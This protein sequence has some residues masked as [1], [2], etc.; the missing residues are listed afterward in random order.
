ML[1][2]YVL[3]TPAR[4]EAKFI[5]LTLESVVAQ[6]VRPL[7]WVIVSDGSTDGTDEIVRKF[8]DTHDWIELLRMPGRSERD[9]AGK[10]HAF[11][12]GRAR[13]ADLAYDV[14]G[15]LDADVS[16][17]EGHFR[18]LVSKFAE[19]PQL[20]VVG[21]P[22]REGS[23]QYDYR[24]TNIENVWGGCQ[25]FR[26]ECFESIGG[27]VAI[28]GG[29]IDH[30]AVVSARMKG[31]RTRTF[32]E[33]VCLHHRILGTAQNGGLRAKFNYGAKDYAVGNHPLWELFRAVYQ[34][35]QRPFVIAGLALA[36]G[37]FWSMIRL[38]PR[39]VS[40]DLVAFTRREQMQRLSGLSDR[41]SLVGLAWPFK[42]NKTAVRGGI[43]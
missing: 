37:Y 21:A 20:G 36:A 24:F 34:M 15:N 28:P 2:T 35:K 40:D 31:W 4:N 5:E 13:V 38:V 17:G 32:T 30:I 23:Y 42:N 19:H 10:V 39:R 25:L 14:I 27:Y 16:F 18:H 8:T 26:K 1:P 22:F 9:F 33:S 41:K 29:S 11:N 43:R 12:A 6:T 3:I 7:K